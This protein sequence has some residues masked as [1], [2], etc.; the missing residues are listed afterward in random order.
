MG[1][2]M[3]ELS[4]AHTAETGGRGS[5]SVQDVSL[6]YHGRRG[7]VQALDKVAFEIRPNEFTVIV[8]PSGCGKSSF[9]YLAAGLAEVTSGEI[10]VN[11]T[12]VEGPGRDRGMV[13][14]SYTLFPWLTVRQNV[15]YGPRRAGVDSAKRREISDHYLN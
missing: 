9:L 2:A 3:G 1:C 14:Q 11:G 10:L 15:E 4:G 6:I 12:R 13:F 8:G 5:L 7:D